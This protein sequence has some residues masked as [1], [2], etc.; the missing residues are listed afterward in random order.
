MNQI[1]YHVPECGADEQKDLLSTVPLKWAC[2]F[3]DLLKYIV[4]MKCNKIGAVKTS[5]LG[6]MNPYSEIY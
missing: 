4:D 6:N 3:S 1:S 2:S 5:M